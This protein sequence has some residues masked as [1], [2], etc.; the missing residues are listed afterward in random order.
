MKHEKSTLE[1]VTDARGGG[2]DDLVEALVNAQ[3]EG[4]EIIK[5]SGGSVPTDEE[6][7][8]SFNNTQQRISGI[9][10]RM[11]ATVEDYPELHSSEQ[12]MELQAQLEGTENRINV[13]RT[14]FNEAVSSFNSAIR[15]LP[16]NLIASIGDF[17]RK[18]YFK[19]DSGSEKAVK[20]EFK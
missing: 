4:S 13:A 1:N 18:A 17:K 10:H 14:R 7:I 5:E 11:M 6:Y 12:M 16:G 3:K 2:L 8:T 19:S 20:V 9:M 15:V